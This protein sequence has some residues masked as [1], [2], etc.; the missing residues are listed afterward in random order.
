MVEA[1]SLESLWQ[2]SLSL[3]GWSS[4]AAQAFVCQWAPST[5][6]TY[7]KMICQFYGFLQQ[8]SVGVLQVHEAHV[9]AFLQ[10][11]ADDSVH[12]KS[13]LQCAVAT[14]G[15]LF[16]GWRCKSPISPRIHQLVTVLVKGGTQLPMVPSCVFS[17]SAF[18]QLFTAWNRRDL[19]M[20]CLRLKCLT[21]ISIALM[22]CPSDVAPRSVSVKHGVHKSEVFRLAQVQ[23]NLDGSLSF[24]LFGTE[25]DY[26]HDGHV[27]IL[28]PALHDQIMCPVSAFQLYQQAVDKIVPWSPD[29]PVFLT[30]KKPYQALSS[31]G[32]AKVLNKALSLSGQSQFTAK[33][34]RPTGASMGV[35]NGLN[36]DAV[37]AVG[38]W[39]NR[40]TFEHHYVHTKPDQAFVDTMFRNN[41]LDGGK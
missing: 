21:L 36:P 23:D 20:E 39:K 34:F 41:S 12:P 26:S 27:V 3:A 19:D 9:A 35:Q 38:R 2:S 31:S 7:N 28:Q 15:H 25:N 4:S 18:R 24:S 13:V 5:R 22:L 17:I 32:V 1:P 14:L 29:R 37:R 16:N 8:N 33:S 6:D 11:I 40:E 10:Q 30:L